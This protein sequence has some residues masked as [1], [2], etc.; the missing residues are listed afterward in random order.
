MQIEINEQEI[1]NDI[2]TRNNELSRKIKEQVTENLVEKIT[3]EIENEFITQDCW[4]HNEEIREII[5]EDLEQKQTELVKK[6]LKGFYDSY[7]YKK[8][9]L[10]ILKKLKEFINEN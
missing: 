10:A 6:I 3:N 5:L 2:L 9:N 8:D 1:L 7:R 4:S